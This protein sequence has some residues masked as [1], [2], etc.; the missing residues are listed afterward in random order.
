MKKKAK[1]GLILS[2]IKVENELNGK[3]AWTKTQIDWI[4][5]KDIRID[6]V[7][8]KT[9]K[10]VAKV[11]DFKY[12]VLMNYFSFSHEVKCICG[13]HLSIYHLFFNCRAALGLEYKAG[14]Y[15]YR[16]YLNYAL[17]QH[18]NCLLEHAWIVKWC[19][20]KAMSRGIMGK[21]VEDI[22]EY[23]CNTLKYYE[24]LHLKYL[25]YKKKLSSFFLSNEISMQINYFV[26]YGLD[27]YGLIYEKPDPI[28]PY[29]IN[30]F[31]LSFDV[32]H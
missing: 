2:Q 5:K 21:K 31:T 16:K 3:D 8:K 15:Y 12:K 11:D 23:F 27:D 1:L 20:W 26:F 6:E 10:T 13:E 32:P 29:Y 22:L 9:L 30:A 19:I 28:Y 4:Y 7:L 14:V 25:Q 18:D 17:F 24:L